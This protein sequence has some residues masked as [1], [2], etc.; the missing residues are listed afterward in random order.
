MCFL[1]LLLKM[2]ARWF[3]VRHR[4][5]HRK[6]V[7]Y[8]TTFKVGITAINYHLN[9]NCLLTAEMEMSYTNQFTVTWLMNISESITNYSF[10]LAWFY[11]SF[12][13]SF[14]KNIFLQSEVFHERQ[15]PHLQY[16]W[17]WTEKKIL[18]LKGIYTILATLVQHR[19]Q[20]HLYNTWMVETD[21]NI[22]SFTANLT[23]DL[24]KT[25]FSLP[26]LTSFPNN[27]VIKKMEL[28]NSLVCYLAP[29]PLQRWI[30]SGMGSWDR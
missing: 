7:R 27:T 20:K 11:G 3:N 4:W 2:R 18:A 23:L 19:R 25:F 15:Q 30:A 14:F 26:A 9:N 5:N 6:S 13:L 24:K 16:N 21:L 10:R 29:I 17:I 22:T 1:S 12:A 28:V 8:R